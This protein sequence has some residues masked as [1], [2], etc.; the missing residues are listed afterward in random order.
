MKTKYRTAVIIPARGETSF[1]L[2]R[3][4]KNVTEELDKEKD[5]VQVVFDGKHSEQYF[6]SFSPRLKLG[7]HEN[8]FLS[9][10][11]E[12]PQGVGQARHWGI[13]ES[14]AKYII[15]AD[16]HMNFVKGWYAK[17]LQHLKEHENHLVCARMQSLNHDWQPYEGQKYWGAHLVE[18]SREPGNQWWAISA[19]WNREKVC[20]KIGAIMGACY[21]FSK[22][23][24]EKLGLPLQILRGWGQ[25]EELLSLLTHLFGGEIHLLDCDVEHVY[26]APRIAL[27]RMT[28]EE[29]MNVWVNRY[30]VVDILPTK[31]ETKK[32]LK[33][34]L[35]NNNLPSQLDEVYQKRRDEI[36]DF[37]DFVKKNAVKQY[38][39]LRAEGLVT[40][41]SDEEQKLTLQRNLVE[42]DAQ[43]TATRPDP[44]II[45]RQLVRCPRCDALDSFVQVR[46]T[47]VVGSVVL[48][49][50]R[51]KRCGYPAQVR[52][53]NP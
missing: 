35:K 41:I 7:R 47:Q 29:T 2:Q 48:A 1:N 12:T 49:Y 16:A 18:M 4:L 24:Y 50:A 22:K 36:E 32:E 39:D 13:V 38:E 53:F 34:W 5:I 30:A 19:K 42:A 10:P 26:A 40:K 44:V 21:G 8:I 6:N 33:A 37:A 31:A 25:D 17:F 46:G 23:W 15:L 3:T 43:R 9:M 14:D 11:F 20:G 52:F 27:A 28:L 45:R 51:C